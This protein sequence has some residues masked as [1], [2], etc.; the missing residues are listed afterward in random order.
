MFVKKIYSIFDF[1][2]K[3]SLH[4]SFCVLCL[5]AVSCLRLNVEFN[6]LIFFFV[7]NATVI[8]YNFIKYASTLPYYF[9]VNNISIKKIQYLSFLSGFFFNSNSFFSKNSNNCFWTFRFYFLCYLCYC[10]EGF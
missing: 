8:V 6:F 1:Y 7:F 9:L 4:L 5:M 3:S 2:I 10:F